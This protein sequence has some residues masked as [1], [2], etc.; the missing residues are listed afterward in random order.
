MIQP[1]IN[2]SDHFKNMYIRQVL[3]ISRVA[4][5]EYHYLAL[6]KVSLATLMCGVV[7]KMYV[8]SV[9]ESMARYTEIHSYKNTST[10]FSH[11]HY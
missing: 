9:S 2:D 3:S 5:G 4:Q 11:W 7:T 10:L 8:S 1:S 6:I